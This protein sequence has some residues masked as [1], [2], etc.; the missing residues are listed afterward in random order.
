MKITWNGNAANVGKFE[1]RVNRANTQGMWEATIWLWLHPLKSTRDHA[2]ID[3]ARQWC[4]RELL[5]LVEPMISQARAEG[6]TQAYE[7]CEKIAD[8]CAEMA[9]VD[10]DD[11]QARRSEALRIRDAIR[12]RRHAGT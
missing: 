4:E 3:A 12:V 10:C 7:S 1:L 8:E 2:S 5:K 11:W 9:R 6:A